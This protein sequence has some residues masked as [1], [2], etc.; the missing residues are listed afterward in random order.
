MHQSPCKGNC[1]NSIPSRLFSM[2]IVRLLPCG[3]STVARSRMGPG[4]LLQFSGS[5]VPITKREPVL[6]VRTEPSKGTVFFVSSSAHFQKCFLRCLLRLLPSPRF[7]DRWFVWIG[8]KGSSTPRACLSGQ[9]PYY[10]LGSR[11]LRCPAMRDAF[12]PRTLPD[13]HGAAL[14]KLVIVVE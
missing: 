13:G 3:L 5:L 9:R 4:R 6:I 11:T 1:F 7:S 12:T 10:A 8:V 14:A 2:I